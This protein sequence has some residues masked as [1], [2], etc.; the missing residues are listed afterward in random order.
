MN[1]KEDPLCFFPEK[2]QRKELKQLQKKK[3]CRGQKLGE[4]KGESLELND[5]RQSHSNYPFQQ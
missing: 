2:N 4:K 1:A 5:I 3:I